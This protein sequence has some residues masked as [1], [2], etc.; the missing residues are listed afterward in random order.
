[1]GDKADT[2]APEEAKAEA[3]SLE[4]QSVCGVGSPMEEARCKL[5][6][7]GKKRVAVAI[8]TALQQVWT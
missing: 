4:G 7:R 3:P 2:P 8:S 6:R 1:M 5:S